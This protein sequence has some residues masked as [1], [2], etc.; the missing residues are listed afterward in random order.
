MIGSQRGPARVTH[1]D[2]RSARHGFKP[3]LH[4]RALARD[5]V[6]SPPFKLESLRRLPDRNASHREHLRSYGR[7]EHFDEM[8]AQP[9][10]EP[11]AAGLFSRN[12]KLRPGPPP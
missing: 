2:A 12:A 3:N 9:R 5:E 11:Q 10:L 4:V 7:L 6:H 1:G 8:P